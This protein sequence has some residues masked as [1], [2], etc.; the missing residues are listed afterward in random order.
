MLDH[1]SIKGFQSL[2]DVDID[3]GKFTVMVGPSGSGKSAFVRA[4]LKMVRNDAVS[5]T[6]GGEDWS[7]LPPKV[8]N[9]EV[10]LDIDGRKI[11]WVKGKS[12]SYFIDG[13]SLHKVGRGC[14]DEV[15]DVLKMREL[16]FDGADSYHLNFA[17]QFD[18]P[19]LLDDSG[20]KV[21][22]ILGEITNVNVLYSANR[23]ANSLKSAATKTLSVRQQD[24]ERQQE[25][26]QQYMYLPKERVNLANAMQLKG[27]VEEDAE[28]FKELCAYA[29]KV[30]RLQQALQDSAGRLEALQELPQAVVLLDAVY[31]DLTVFGKL[32]DYGMSLGVGLDDAAQIKI[33]ARR[34]DPVR[35]VDVAVLSAELTDYAAMLEYEQAL[36]NLANHVAFL[37]RESKA[38]AAIVSF[39]M[40]ALS[41]SMDSYKEMVKMLN[42]L[43]TQQRHTAVV[44]DSFTTAHESYENAVK[45]YEEFIA[46]FPECPL[47]GQ[48]LPCNDSEEVLA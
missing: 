8:A 6:S 42:Q 32:R 36:R 2:R 11:K 3:L 48:T 28:T 31:A 27:V 10:T 37:K 22:K 4:V 9:A 1:I 45:E 26:L 33:T 30:G 5:G 14:P 40:S 35:K 7:H 41:V 29:G 44:K 17:Q 18:M 20:S 39:D 24:L 21:A 19:F 15:Q 25:L 47:C 16:T 13:E 23:Q 38:T 12:N 46:E 43:S 34:L